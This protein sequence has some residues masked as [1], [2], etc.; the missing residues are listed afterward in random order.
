MLR[1]GCGV[2]AGLGINGSK[3]YADN[4]ADAAL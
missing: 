3:L 2:F 1:R 4:E